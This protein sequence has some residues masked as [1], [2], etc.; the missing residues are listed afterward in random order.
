M[1]KESEIYYRHV[2]MG[3]EL[4]KAKEQVKVLEGLTR[5]KDLLVYMVE[6]GVD[7]RI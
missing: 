7:I 3:L 2:N 1:V 4:E 6:N 5:V